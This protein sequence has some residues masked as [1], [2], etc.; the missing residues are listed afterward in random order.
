[1]PDTSRLF[2][3]ESAA[4]EADSPP[5]LLMYYRVGKRITAWRSL[6]IESLDGGRSWSDPR[7][8]PDGC[9][10][11]IK[12]KPIVLADGTWLA[13]SSVETDSEW[14]CQIERSEDHGATWDIAQT[15]KL[16]GHPKGIIQPTL[17][18]S[19]PGYVHALMR[20]RGVGSIC[21]SDS[22]DGGK[23]WSAAYTT[24]LPN[25][26][27][28]I[29]VVRLVPSPGDP[30]YD[31]GYAPLVLAFN[32][33][34]E[35]RT[36]LVLAV[37]YDNGETWPNRLTLQDVPGEYS[38]PSIIP[39]ADGVAVSYTFDRHHIQFVRHSLEHLQG[40]G[41]DVFSHLG[42]HSHYPEWISLHSQANQ[43]NP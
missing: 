7:P 25:N 30:G 21:R 8:L 2:A 15:I 5:R 23:T 17:W 24:D 43:A 37:S 14:Y 10:G 3:E 1:M 35:G 31:E 12:N 13:G 9:L 32:P 42:D 39:T 28:G 38:Y 40:K 16:E 26:N 18:E 41:D 4:L 34:T 29:D 27:S 19:Q 20:S 6:V 22:M 33:I 11:P 36:P